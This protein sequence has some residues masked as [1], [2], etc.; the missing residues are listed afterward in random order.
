MIKLGGKCFTFFRRSRNYIY[1]K[2]RS[3]SVNDI[4]IGRTSWMLNDSVYTVGTWKNPRWCFD[5]C[6]ELSSIAFLLQFITWGHFFFRLL[7]EK[8]WHVD[9][10]SFSAIWMRQRVLVQLKVK[11]G[12]NESI[13]VTK[14]L[15]SMWESRVCFLLSK[16]MYL[17]LYVKWWS[18]RFHMYLS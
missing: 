11:L 18:R 14:L 2:F 4:Y 7:H 6:P 9:L 3:F 15:N 12:I 16:S 10:C 1:I 8:N 5:K 17:S 13:C